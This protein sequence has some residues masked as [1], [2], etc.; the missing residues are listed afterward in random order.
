MV[1]HCK[2]DHHASTSPRHHA[3]QA[4]SVNTKTPQPYPE[5]RL[6][7]LG[8]PTQN[9]GLTPW[10]HAEVADVISGTV[11]KN[12]RDEGESTPCTPVSAHVCV[13][14]C[15][16]TPTSTI[17]KDNNEKMLRRPTQCKTLAVLEET[18]SG[19]T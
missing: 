5:A 12:G 8:L 9:V 2:H 7:A 10:H 3:S 6:Q 4:L 1:R 16:K 11:K 14:V 18:L 17:Y 15:A 19:P 13:C